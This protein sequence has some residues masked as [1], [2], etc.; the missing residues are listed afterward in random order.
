MLRSWW[1]V[2][3][4]YFNRQ[5][6]KT[7]W[8]T[9][10]QLNFQERKK[11]NLHNT[12]SSKQSETMKRFEMEKKVELLSLRSNLVPFFFLLSW[13]EM[14]VTL[15]QIIS[16]IEKKKKNFLVSYNCLNKWFI[17]YWSLSIRRYKTQSHLWSNNH[18]ISLCNVASWIIC[19]A[20][21]LSLPKF[22]YLYA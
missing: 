8:Q 12:Y 3:Y 1:N 4:T 18:R 14:G 16:M 19:R 5:E 22:L 17:Q 6:K 21:F 15:N 13:R 20:R 9:S 11:K 7:G 10:T 2:A